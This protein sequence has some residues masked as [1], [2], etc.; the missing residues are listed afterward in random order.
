MPDNTSL[1][2]SVSEYSSCESVAY[3]SQSLTPMTFIHILFR[4][5]SLAARSIKTIL[6]AILIQSVN[7]LVNKYPRLEENHF[8]LFEL[9][10]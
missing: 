6:L 7:Y 3:G 5:T 8:H 2:N 9:Q 4:L 10:D 1:D